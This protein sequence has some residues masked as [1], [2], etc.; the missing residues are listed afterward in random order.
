[1][2]E[3]NNRGEMGEDDAQDDSNGGFCSSEDKSKVWELS[4]SPPFKRL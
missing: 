2:P 1:M 3:K 4:S